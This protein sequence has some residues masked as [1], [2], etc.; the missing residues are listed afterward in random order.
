MYHL[1]SQFLGLFLWHSYFQSIDKVL[2][3]ALVPH[4]QRKIRW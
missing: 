3:S 2:S 1:N 4:T